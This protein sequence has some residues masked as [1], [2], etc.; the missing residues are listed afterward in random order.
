[1]A[2]DALDAYACALAYQLSGR[3]KYAD[4]ALQFINAWSF[5]NK[6]YSGYDGN[7]VMAYSGSAMIMAGE[8]LY[9]Y[10]GWKAGDKIA[11]LKWAR[12]VYEKCVNEIRGKKNNWGDWGRFGSV[13]VAHLLDDPVQMDVNS[14]LIKSDLF[15]KIEADGH[16]PEES[17][18]KANGIW[19]TY[20]SLAPITAAAWVI[21]QSKGEDLFDMEKEGRSVK[22]A[23]DYLHYHQLN[24]GQWPWFPDPVQGTSENWP[25]DLYEAMSGIYDDARYSD[26]VQKARPLSSTSHHFAWVFP[27]LMRVQRRKYN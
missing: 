10:K 23:L 16:M 21:F 15:Q 12:N 2:S 4:Q 19:Y 18:R 8:L 25:G 13:L 6:G 14:G 20:F 27:T 24:P 11:Y 7:L 22:T 3:K 9:N 1:M 17:R 5:Q 26:Y